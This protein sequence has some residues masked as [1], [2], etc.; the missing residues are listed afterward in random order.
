MFQVVP[1]DQI[2]T[3]VLQIKVVTQNFRWFQRMYAYT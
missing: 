1:K 3:Y 2:L